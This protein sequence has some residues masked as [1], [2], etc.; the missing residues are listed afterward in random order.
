MMI[1]R[2][3]MLTLGV[4][5]GLVFF[6]SGF[7]AEAFTQH[8]VMP[9]MVM[10]TTAAHTL[11][12]ENMIAQGM[13]VMVVSQDNASSGME[14]CVFEC[15]TKTPPMTLSEKTKIS[16]YAVNLFSLYFSSAHSLV[17]GVLV[18]GVTSGESPGDIA[19]ADILLSVQKRE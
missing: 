7:C 8:Q 6:S 3:I 2:K 18:R 9:G 13:D 19:S 15:A 17:P 4:V 10:G 1:S 14:N 12:V 5:C 11:S 16:S